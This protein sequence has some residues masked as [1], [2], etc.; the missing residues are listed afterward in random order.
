MTHNPLRTFD[1]FSLHDRSQLSVLPIALEEIPVIAGQ[2]SNP[3]LWAELLMTL[4][5]KIRQGLL[6]CGECGETIEE[7]PAGVTIICHDDQNSGVSLAWC[8]ECFETP[9]AMEARVEE[10]LS[11]FSG[12]VN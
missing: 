3:R 9:D 8:E 11:E 1:V 4:A 5:F 12:K 6:L 7:A 2:S 10:F